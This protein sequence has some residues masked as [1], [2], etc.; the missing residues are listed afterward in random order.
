MINANQLKKG[1]TIILDGELY[2]IV[3]KQHVKP[4]KGGAFISS[5][6]KRLSDNTIVNKTLRAQEKIEVAFIEERKLQYLY[7]KAEIYYFMFLDTYEQKAVNKNK[8][9]DI[10]VFLKDGMELTA[11]FYESKIVNFNLPTFIELKVVRTQPGVKGNTVQGGTKPAVLETNLEVQVPLFINK[12]D[13]VKVD[14]RT[15]EYVERV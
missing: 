12:G 6:I 8:V 1:M 4:G 7:H 3:E 14:T 2:S 15:K 13:I 9:K 10:D 5:K 11:D